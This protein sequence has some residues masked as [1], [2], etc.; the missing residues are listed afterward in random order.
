M[1]PAVLLALVVCAVTARASDGVR[2]A[3]R[4]SIA[5]S[6][7]DS[8]VSLTRLS[9]ERL[10]VETLD[11]DAGKKRSERVQ[12]DPEAMQRVLEAA[13]IEGLPVTVSDAEALSHAPARHH[14]EASARA[15]SSRSAQPRDGDV[16]RKRLIYEGYQTA[17]ATYV[18]GL[19]IPLAYGVTDTRLLI[20]LPLITAPV[21]FGTHLWLSRDQDFGESHLKGTTYASSM[22][23]YAATALPLAFSSDA[24]DGYRVAALLGAAAYP[25]GVWY[26][27]HLGDVYRSNP[28]QLDIKL[29]FALGYAFAGFVTPTLYFK[30]PGN[31]G[32]PTLRIALG[33]SVAM[34][35]LGGVVADYYRSGPNVSPGVSTGILTHAVLGGLGGLEVAALCNASSAR[36][37]IG[38]AVL[39]STLGFTEGVFFFR[40]SEDSFERSF[41]AALGGLGGAM[42]GTGLGLILYDSEASSHTQKIAWSSYII[43]GTWLGYGAVYYLTRG[44][45]G[46][47]NV[48]ATHP[49][50]TLRDRVSPLHSQ[51]PQWA[52]NPLP[53]LEPVISRGDLAMR[54]RIPGFSRHF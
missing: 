5:L 2:L 19:S 40:S 51:S 25:L 52:F 8:I 49:S 28:D 31:S 30:H 35:A 11:L 14:Q 24:G 18:Y 39:G 33:Q 26:G 7:S 21:A 29:Y 20:A 43:G 16:D 17:L 27:Y 45:M 46:T 44:M 47:G 37:W 36:P 10:E 48:G 13:S 54:W 4:G 53:V 15:A 1:R 32:N 12:L 9:A 23:V 3:L 22:A 41:Y 6:E 50:T 38:A 34:A 42:V